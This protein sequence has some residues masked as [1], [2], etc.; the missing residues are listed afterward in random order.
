MAVTLIDP[1]VR[2]ALP[3]VDARS[4]DGSKPSDVEFGE[5]LADA[6]TAANGAERHAESLSTRFADGDPDVGIHE[7]ELDECA[8]D[9]LLLALAS[10]LDQCD[11]HVGIDQME[12]VFH[13]DLKHHVGKILLVE[14]SVEVSRLSH[15]F[16][17][18]VS[19]V[20]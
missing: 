16:R 15:W 4:T 7:V 20:V 1:G 12:S 17:L 10:F 2:A 6:I 3:A 18:A 9:M 14:E 5:A 11:H 13:L 19:V 8:S